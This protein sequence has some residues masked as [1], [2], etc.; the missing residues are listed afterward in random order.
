[1]KKISLYSAILLASLLVLGGCSKKEEPTTAPDS[2]VYGTWTESFFE[3]G[4]TFN[5]D[6]T[7]TD[8]FWDLT[9][10]YTAGGG[11]MA[12]TYDSELYGIATYTYTVSGDTLTMTRTGDE[13]NSTFSY[14]KQTGQQTRPQAN[15]T[16]AE[17]TGAA[18]DGAETPESRE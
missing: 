17:E 10:T 11:E 3:S 8:T 5:A 6:G 1:M 2:S 15:T 9:F 14:T 16:E 7:G 18:E 13:E 4:Y 12:I